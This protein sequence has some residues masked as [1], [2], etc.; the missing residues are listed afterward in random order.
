MSE[1]DKLISSDSFC[2]CKDCH[3]IFGM[4]TEGG[5]CPVCGGKNWVERHI[6]S[7]GMKK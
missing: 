3:L 4:P 5:A 2:E 7:G 6:E 1:S